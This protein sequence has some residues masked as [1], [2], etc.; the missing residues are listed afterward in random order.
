MDTPY[1]IKY[2][3]TNS[4][5]RNKLILTFVILTF[6]V[7][8]C[9]KN[10]LYEKSTNALH[11]DI[12]NIDDK[13]I[14]TTLLSDVSYIPLENTAESTIGFINKVL[15]LNNFYILDRKMAKAVFVFSKEG[16]F[17]TKIHKI[18]KG[19]GEYRY[20]TDFDIDLSGNVYIYDHQSG[21]VLKYDIKGKHLKTYNVIYNAEQIAVYDSLNIIFNQVSL[22]NNNICQL[23]SYN[24]LENKKS[25]LLKAREV[26]DTDNRIPDFTSQRLMKY[27]MN[28]YYTPPFSNTVYS[29]EPDNIT[30]TAEITPNEFFM[31]KKTVQNILKNKQDISDYPLIYQIRNYFETKDYIHIWIKFGSSYDIFYSKNSNKYIFADNY[32]YKLGYPLSDVI[33]ATEEGYIAKIDPMF[34]HQMNLRNPVNLPKELQGKGLDSN[35]V[36]I[37]YTL[38]PF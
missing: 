23:V 31:D 33:G 2:K 1:L 7:L 3:K 11:I 13:V 36:L 38:K 32:N 14:D 6:L 15:Y 16:K 5:K 25:I 4:M 22:T 8:C 26:F 10:T 21:K 18:G 9:K 37:L 20:L 27:K 24:L 35:P 12:K 34:L 28:L 17:L 19:P 30:I 29:I